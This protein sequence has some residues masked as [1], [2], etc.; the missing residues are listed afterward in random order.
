MHEGIVYVPVAS[1]EETRAADPEY[2]CCSFRGSVV[3]LRATDGSQVWKTYMVDVPRETGKT[4]RGTPRLSPSGVGIWATP[5]VDA[6]RR[7]LYV[8][9]GDNY[10]SPATDLSDAVV[11]LDLANGRVVWSQQVTKGDAY[12]GGCGGGTANCPADKGPDFDF[13]SPAILTKRPDGRDVLVAGQKSG[14]VFAFDPDADGRILWQTRIGRGGTGGGIQWGMSSDGRNV[15]AAVADPGRTRQ[16]NPLDPRRYALDPNTG[17][18]VTALRLAD[19]SRQWFS[20]PIPCPA[21]A[22]VGC[23]PAQPAAVTAIPGVVFAAA[24][25]GHLRAHSAEN[26]RVLW[27]FDTM[28]DFQTVNGVKANG[29]SIDGPGAVVAGGMVFISSGYPRNGGVSGN[30]LLAFAP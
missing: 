5:T 26:G 3:A 12:N 8:T 4:E 18:G 16:N 19:G 24:Y 21:R 23:S 9:T 17:G 2:P 10:S 6:V 11:A 29:G 15:Y 7:R 25:D 13:G 30:V 14:I 27:D 20:E 28:R 1:W 22:P